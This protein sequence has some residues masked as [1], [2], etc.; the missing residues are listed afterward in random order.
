MKL[1][2]AKSGATKL[3]YFL[4]ELDP[5]LSAVK[6]SELEQAL[7][8]RGMQLKAFVDGDTLAQALNEA[9]PDVLL[10]EA[11]FVPALS[12]MLDH[13]DREHPGISMRLALVAVNKSPNPT[14]RLLAGLGGADEYLESASAAEIAEC[15]AN[16]ANSADDVPY[17][18]LIVDDD[19]QQAMFCAG[20]LKRK[21]M[22]VTSAL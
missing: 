12:E 15:V 20:V 16:L 18:I 2:N 4:A 13:L 17:Q 14:R 19:R 3:C 6:P 22:E 7:A 21:G 9:Q 10:C 11:A 8:Q 5:Q 1:D